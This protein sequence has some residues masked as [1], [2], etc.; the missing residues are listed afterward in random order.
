MINKSKN[1]I[2][3]FVT[4]IVALSSF[5]I[6]STSLPSYI[7]PQTLEEELEQIQK[8]REE[9]KEKIEEVTKTESQYRKEVDNVEGQLLSALGELDELNKKLAEAKAEVD[10]TTIELV[11]KEEELKRI[12]DEL[13]ESIKKL[14]DRVVAI[15]KNGNGDMLEVILNAENF[16]DFISKLKLMNLFAEQDTQNIISIKEKREATIGIKK[17]IIDL[18]ERQKDYKSEVEELV[19]RAEQKTNEIGNLYSEK[20]GLLS[21]TTANKNALISMEKELA[22]KEAEVKRILESYKYGSAPSGKFLWPV[23]GRLTSGFGNRV[24]PIFGVVRFHSGIDLAASYGTPVKAADGGQVVQAGYFGGYG[25]SV[26]IYHGGG[27]ST[28]YAHLSS[29]NVSVGQMV[30]RGQVIGLVGSTGW[31]TGPHLHFEVRINGVAQNPRD[32]LQ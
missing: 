1:I 18:R 27:F 20:K 29:I 14:N 25:N 16:I 7:Y 23:A 22:S 2:A 26:M 11:L 17:S 21:R 28:W 30:G 19:A 4:I 13:T 12:E 31:S 15:Y 24:H 3:I 5:I 6:T 9:T 10:K 32:Y 8:E